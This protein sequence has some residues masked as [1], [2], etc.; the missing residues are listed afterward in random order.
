[1]NNKIR[2][3][4]AAIAAAF[5]AP[6]AFADTP[7]ALAPVVVSATRVEHSAFDTAASVNFVGREQIQDGQAQA[8]LAEPL[9]RVPGMFALNRQNYAQDLLIS[10]RGFGANST[11]GARGIKIFVD[12]IPGT[13]AD[14]QG[15][16]SHI[17]LASADHIEVLRGPFSTL[18]GNASGGVINVFTENGKPGTAVTPY[19]EAGSFGLHKYGV[20]VSGEQGKVNYVLD[21][22]KLELAGFRQHSTTDRENRNAKLLFRLSDDT[23]V[24]FAAN[25]LSLSAQDPLGLTAT[26]LQQDHTQAGSY[27]AAYNT[28]KTV[29]QTQGGLVLT[30]RINGDNSLVLSPYFGTRHTVQ[31]QAGSNTTGLSPANNGVI[32]LARTFYGVDG[33]WLH[34]D[35]IMGMPLQLVTGLESNRN[36]DHRLTYNNLAGTQQKPL[37]TNQDLDQSASNQDVYLQAVLRASERATLT[38]GL[39]NSQTTLNSVSNNSAML[40][41]NHD[42]KDTTGMASAQ[43]YVRDDTNVYVSYGTGFDTPTLNQVAYSPDF[44]NGKAP[45]NQGNFGL[46]AATT[47]Q[48]EVG[49]KSDIAQVARITLAAFSTTTSNDIV[50]A[51]SSTGRTAFFNAPQTSRKGIEL[52]ASFMLPYQLQADIACTLLQATVDQAYAGSAGTINAGNRIPGVPGKGMFAELKWLKADKGAEVAIEGRGVGSMAATDANTSGTF[53]GGYAVMNARVV[54]RQEAGPWSV[55]EFARLDNLFDRSYVG[56]VIVN[57]ASSQFFESAPGRNWTVGASASYKF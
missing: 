43:Y 25:N 32:D 12:G 24:Q 14:G 1:M 26:Q 31:F 28:R 44:L 45:T 38:A 55:K 15:Q 22:G 52:G 53:A 20:K 21:E 3:S 27:A 56:S 39:R 41:G 42:Y 17:D 16:I 40:G 54:L 46:L 57:Q 10:S 34:Q 51:A 49:L 50:V 7:T 8:N 29:D 36:N 35:Q 18:Y 5:A 13:V 37:G 47:R 11:F 48:L 23:T 19:D 30:Q 33:K 6:Q 9:A 2:I 4:V